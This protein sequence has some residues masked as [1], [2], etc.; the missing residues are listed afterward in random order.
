MSPEPFLRADMYVDEVMPA[1]VNGDGVTDIVN[2]KYNEGPDRL[3]NTRDDYGVF[4]TLLNTTRTQTHPLRGLS[5]SNQGSPGS[6]SG[7][8]R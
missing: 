4:V 5:R 3:V 2:L 7:R 8:F 1:D 6:D